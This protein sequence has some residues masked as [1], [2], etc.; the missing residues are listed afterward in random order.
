MQVAARSAAERLNIRYVYAS[1]Q[2]NALPSPAREGP[3]VPP[4][5]TDNR[6]LWNLGA[7]SIDAV[8]P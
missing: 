1:C 5:V 8:S 7:R 6:A 4:G 3:S 2:R